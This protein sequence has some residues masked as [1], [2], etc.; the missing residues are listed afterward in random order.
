[1]SSRAPLLALCAVISVFAGLTG[2]RLAYTLAYVLILLLVVGFVWSRLLG[3]RLQITREAPQGSRMVGEA[4]HERFTVHNGSALPLPYC[5]VYDHSDMPGY[6]A[7]RAFALNPGGSV[8]WGAQGLF[9]RRGRVAFGPLE[10]RFGDPFGLFP[11]SLRIPAGEPVTVYP[12]I[13]AVEDVLSPLWLGSSAMEQ[14]RGRAVDIAPEVSSVREYDPSDGMSRIHWPSVAR[15]G[16]LMSR[17]YDTRQSADVLVILDLARGT[18]IGA[19]P[20]SSL[21]YAI[22]LAASVCHAGLVRGQAV[23][24][25]GND[26][27]LVNISAARGDAQRLRILDYLAVAA[28]TG[29]T[30]V[31][32]TITTPPP[33]SRRSS[34]P[35]SAA[36][37]T[38][39]FM[40]TPARSA[41]AGRRCGCPRHGVSRW[42]GGSFG[43]VTSSAVPAGFGSPAF[44]RR[45]LRWPPRLL[46]PL[47]DRRCPGRCWTT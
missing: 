43:A 28:D 47:P 40:S 35:G 18:H 7:G 24:L 20:E 42:T 34:R 4:F 38:S 12:T 31:A 26:R 32:E 25:V 27:D 2:V 13:H 33:G 9:S 30:S 46:A 5:E 44:D 10:A 11:R 6:V 19:A 45:G 8:G 17:V 16:R 41:P 3:R 14:R 1:M 15:T 37:V 39:A 22:S 29:R 23:G 21:E 36:N